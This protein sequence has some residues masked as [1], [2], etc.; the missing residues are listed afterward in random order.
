MEPPRKKMKF[1]SRAIAFYNPWP[2]M[3]GESYDVEAIFNG[4]NGIGHGLSKTCGPTFHPYDDV[5][6]QKFRSYMELFIE[7]CKDKMP[8]QAIVYIC[9]HGLVHPDTGELH[10]M[11]NDSMEPK[12]GDYGFYRTSISGPELRAYIE[13]LKKAVPDGKVLVFL[14][15][16]KSGALYYKSRQVQ[17]LGT[18]GNVYSF[19]GVTDGRFHPGAAHVQDGSGCVVFMSSGPTE[20]SLVLESKEISESQWCPL[21]TREV[22]KALI[23][24]FSNKPIPVKELIPL[25]KN[26]V[27][28]SSGGSQNPCEYPAH[29]SEAAEKFGNVGLGPPIP[30]DMEVDQR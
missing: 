30:E 1:S 2:E 17:T 13:Q 14:D 19:D 8:K 9:T 15:C 4:V 22:V 21:F 29:W 27:K 25:V 23:W 6:C 3:A 10:L 11:M 16:C 7:T 26:Q 24:G 12:Q 5:S 20:D 18:I 28:A